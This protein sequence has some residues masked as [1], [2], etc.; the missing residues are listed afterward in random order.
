MG[1]LLS[2]TSHSEFLCVQVNHTTMIRKF[3]KNAG[4]DSEEASDRNGFLSWSGEWHAAML[5]FSHGARDPFTISADELP[6][7]DTEHEID[8]RGEPGYY[9]GGFVAGTVAQLALVGLSIVTG[10]A[11]LA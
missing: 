5:G 1:L 4:A 2:E 11:L 8:A 10:H 7:G 3:I 6:Q 9:H